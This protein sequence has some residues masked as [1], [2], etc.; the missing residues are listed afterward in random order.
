VLDLAM[1][2][3]VNSLVTAKDAGQWGQEPK[4]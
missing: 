4:R 2:E 3:A 1:R